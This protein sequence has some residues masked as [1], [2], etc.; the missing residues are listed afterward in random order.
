[1]NK[2]YER[3][4]WQNKPST[5]TKINATN[6]N[7]MDL[8]LDTIDDRVIELDTNKQDKS[9]VKAGNPITFN[10]TDGGVFDK[11][12]VEFIPIQDTS[13]G[14]P[15]P[16][17]ICPITGYSQLNIFQSSGSTTTPDE[18]YTQSLGGTYYSGTYDFATGKLTI[19]KG[20]VDLGSLTWSYESTREFFFATLP[21]IGYQNGTNSY[22]A[23]I[24]ST[25][26]FAGIN[27]SIGAMSVAPDYSLYGRSDTAIEEKKFQKVYIKDSRYTDAATFKT[28]MSG[29]QLVYELATPTETTLTPTQ[30]SALVGDNA[31]WTDGD[32]VTVRIS[33]LID[34]EYVTYDNTSSG[35]TATNVQ[36]AIDEVVTEVNGMTT[37]AA[38]FECEIANLGFCEYIKIGHLVYATYNFTITS[39]I[40]T[41]D[42]IMSGLPKALLTTN[43]NFISIINNSSGYV[44][45][46]KI[47][48]SGNNAIIKNTAARSLAQNVGYSGSFVYLAE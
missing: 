32:K 20:Y 7:K 28:A 13:Q 26:I 42:T 16:D 37:G 12:E 30:I 40:T 44:C 41:S 5:A 22:I 38:T 15:S 47:E 3:I 2:A 25:Y 21:S 23:G 17:H 14:D 11:A 1:M 35:L 27:S 6:L 43:N 36:D 4:N 33:T 19:D 39:N 46:T 29:V 48:N 24:C 45:R 9:I 18:T 34:S 10:I 8:A 31:M